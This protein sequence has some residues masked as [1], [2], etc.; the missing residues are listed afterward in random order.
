MTANL[1]PSLHVPL[2]DV[3]VARLEP[4]DRLMSR[5]RPI[6]RNYYV[7]EVSWIPG[8]VCDSLLSLRICKSEISVR[9]LQIWRIEAV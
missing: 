8:R 4:M 5:S 1:L 2:G 9:P 3:A 6:H 7:L